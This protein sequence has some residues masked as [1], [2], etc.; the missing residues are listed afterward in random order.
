MY[1]LNK[2]CRHK[3]IQGEKCPEIES[4][5]HMVTSDTLVYINSSVFNILVFT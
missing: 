5:F 1:I 2:F 4:N 3:Y